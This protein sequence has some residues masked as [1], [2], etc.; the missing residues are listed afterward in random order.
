MLNL[1]IMV[2]AGALHVSFFL[3]LLRMGPQAEY[4][5]AFL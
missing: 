1:R 5:I 4:Q 3:T 2:F